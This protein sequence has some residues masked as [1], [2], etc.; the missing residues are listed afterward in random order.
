MYEIVYE[1]I[2]LPNF[3]QLHGSETWSLT[4]RERHRER[5]FDNRVLRILEPQT[6]KG[7]LRKLHNELSQ[8]IIFAKY[9]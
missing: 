8:F 6:D 9:N 7:G 4:L 2:Y 5:V 1:F 3:M